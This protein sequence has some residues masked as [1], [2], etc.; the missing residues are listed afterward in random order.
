M[1]TL[2]TSGNRTWVTFVFFFY[3][4]VSLNNLYYLC[5][6]KENITI[7]LLTAHRAESKSCLHIIPKA[8]Q[9]GN[10]IAPSTSCITVAL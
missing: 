7:V 3:S 10:L 8:Q 1:L 6:K 2:L 5:K 9:P 4:S